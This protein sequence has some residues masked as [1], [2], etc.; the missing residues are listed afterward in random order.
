MHRNNL[1]NLIENYKSDLNND[2]FV[3]DKFS[4]FIKNNPDCFKRT[5]EHGHITGS[6]WVMNL[7]RTH[8]LLTHH[9]KL[10]K[11]LQLGGHVDGES[12]VLAEAIREVKEESGLKH[13]KVEYDGIFDLDVHLIPANKKELQHYHF[14]VRFLLSTNNPDE[15]IMSDESHDLKWISLK[16]I[17]NYTNEPS[18]LRMVIK[19]SQFK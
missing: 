6:A 4:S 9:K 7:E 15:I 3:A 8:T 1:L 12:D 17:N 2:S 10:D 14:D 5:L 13:V 11:W 18:I 19:S 16:E